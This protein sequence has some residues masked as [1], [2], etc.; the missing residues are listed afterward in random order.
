MGGLVEHVPP[1]GV[2]VLRAS[3]HVVFPEPFLAE[4][5]RRSSP[6]SNVERDIVDAARCIRRGTAYDNLGRSAR[7]LR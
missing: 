6:R 3:S 7:A 1:V 4:K 5:S 2:R